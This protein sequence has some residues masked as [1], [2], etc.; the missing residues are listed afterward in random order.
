MDSETVECVLSGENVEGSIL[1]AT[2]IPKECRRKVEK[3]ED[4]IST[5]ETRTGFKQ[6]DERTCTSPSGITLE[7]KN[8]SPS[9]N[10]QRED[11]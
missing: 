5:E 8:A 10:K 7:C 4:E 3:D 9:L 1:E 6:W 2:E 11:K